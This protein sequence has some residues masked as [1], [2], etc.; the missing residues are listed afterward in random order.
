VQLS[1]LYKLGLGQSHG[2]VQEV[3]PVPHA[4]LDW[5][6]AKLGDLNSILAKVSPP[7]HVTTDEAA[8]TGSHS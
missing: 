4:L 6:T 2:L 7:A 3:V 1:T 5:T 8:M